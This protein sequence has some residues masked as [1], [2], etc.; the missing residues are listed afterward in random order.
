L[1]DG[2]SATRSSP[3]QVGTAVNWKHV[4]GGRWYSIGTRR[5]GTIWG[6]GQNAAGNLGLNNTTAQNTFTQIGALTNWSV[7]S[8]SAWGGGTGTVLAVK[9]DGTL[10]TWGS[11]GHGQLGLGDT[12]NRSSPVQVG[13]GTTWSKVS[14]KNRS[15]IAVKTDGTLWAW[16][17]NTNGELGLND[18]VY[19]SSPVQVGVLTNWS[20]VTSAIASSFAIKTDG[21]LWAWGSNSFTAL[22]LGD[23]TNRSSPVQ[24]GALTN[25]SKITGSYWNCIAIKTDNTLWSWGYNVSGML[26]LGDSTNRSSPVQVG[27][28]TNWS[29]I[30]IGEQNSIAIK[31][32][33]TLW[34]WG[35]NSS[36]GELG[37]NDRVNRSSPVQVGANT[38][39]IEPDG[40]SGF[41]FA[42]EFVPIFPSP[43]PSIT[44]SRTPTPTP[45]S[46]PPQTLWNF[47]ASSA[48]AGISTFTATSAPNY[49]YDWN[50]SQGLRTVGDAATGFVYTVQPTASY[51]GNNLFQ[52]SF[53]NVNSD[54]C[55]DPGVAI[56]PTSNG[57]TSPIWTWGAQSSRIAAQMNCPQPVIYGYSNGTNGTS[58][59]YSLNTWYTLHFYHEP[60]LGRCRFAVT[61]GQNDWTRSGALFSPEI[62]LNESIASSYYFGIASDND[63]GTLGGQQTAFSGL[64]V[65]P[66]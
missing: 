49:A 42:I 59:T 40:G 51:S 3:V 64:K 43:T 2:T 29:S 56:W 18:T 20:Q 54:N 34:T 66:L 33:G 62:T 41:S 65:T 60:S 6:T 36:Y 48:P 5:D 32:D 13:V 50:V 15:A 17:S 10:W 21:T 45:S 12:N 47:F 39:W 23:S 61:Q 14:I 24:V 52:V 30:G 58:G 8:V 4:Q 37:L 38:N 31:T 63:G 16:G 19:R 27:A 46:S 25:W 22:G 35:S 44:P 57:R 9:T 7:F 53:Y 55:G 1:G 11:N 28:L 26:G